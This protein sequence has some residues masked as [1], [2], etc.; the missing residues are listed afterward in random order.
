MLMLTPVRRFAWPLSRNTVRTRS[1]FSPASWAGRSRFGRGAVSGIAA[2]AGL[3]AAS[4]FAFGAT[5]GAGRAVPIPLVLGVGLLGRLVCRLL[6][7]RRPVGVASFALALQSLLAV[8]VI[9]LS[10]ARASRLLLL[11]RLGRLPL[12]ALHAGLCTGL[13]ALGTAGSRPLGARLRRAALHAALAASAPPPNPRSP[14]P[15]SR[16]SLRR[17]RRARSRR[18][19]H[20]RATA[21]IAA[22]V[23]AALRDRQ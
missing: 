22:P 1:R 4:A 23:G 16:A 3:Y 18:R 10:P 15:P 2:L 9:A 6:V 5:L 17:H 13:G 19:C 20:P 12:T 21:T 14:P 7:A 8:G 11:T